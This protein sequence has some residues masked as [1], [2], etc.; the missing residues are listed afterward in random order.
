ML[1]ARCV[2]VCDLFICFL[3]NEPPAG[4]TLAD[5]ILFMHSSQS[6]AHAAPEEEGVGGFCLGSSL[7]FVDDHNIMFSSSRC[8]CQ[9]D[10]ERCHCFS[11][12]SAPP[13]VNRVSARRGPR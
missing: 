2:P 5:Q 4:S 8:H 10:R 12:L 11:L 9:V 1:P 7:F 13:S 3:P 6:S